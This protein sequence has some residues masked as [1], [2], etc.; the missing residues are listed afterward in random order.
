MVRGSINGPFP[1]NGEDSVG[2]SLRYR[3]KEVGREEGKEGR[4]EGG[5]KEGRKEGRKGGRKKGRME[6]SCRM[7]IM[8]LL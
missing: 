7:V 2:L 8:L 5:R 1:G 6:I 3:Q 4:K